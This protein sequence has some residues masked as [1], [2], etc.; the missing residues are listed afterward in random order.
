MDIINELDLTRG[1]FRFPNGRELYIEEIQYSPNGKD[2]W[3]KRFIPHPHTNPNDPT[4]LIDGHKYRRV[5]HAGDDY[6]QFPEYIVAK[7]GDHSVFRMNGKTLQYKLSLEL[8]DE[9]K[10]LFDFSILKGDKGDKG[11]RG[12]GW[13]IDMYGFLDTRPHCDGSIHDEHHECKP[14]NEHRHHNHIHDH[15][16]HHHDH[17]EHH[18][19][20]DHHHDHH[21]DYHH[22]HIETPPDPPLDT[23][24]NPLPNPHVHRHHHI[25]THHGHKHSTFLSLGNHVISHRDVGTT[26]LPKYH[27]INGTTWL[28]T[29]KESIGTIVV[30]WGSGR[31]ETTVNGITTVVFS[32]GYTCNEYGQIIG[33]EQAP[34]IYNSKGI[35]FACA[36]GYWV[37]LSNVATPTGEVK[38]NPV[39][40][41][42]YLDEKL[43]EVTLTTN[44]LKLLIKDLGVT[45]NK[46]AKS[47]FGNGLEYRDDISKVVVDVRPLIGFGLGSYKDRGDGFYNI[48]VKPT[49]FLEDGFDIEQDK[50]PLGTITKGDIWYTAFVDVSDLICPTSGLTA[51]FPLPEE[52]QRPDRYDLFVKPDDGIKV[53]TKGVGLV[54]DNSIFAVTPSGITLL[55]DSIRATHIN[56]D[57]AGIGLYQ[58]N[59]G[60]LNVGARNTVFGFDSKDELYILDN[61]ITGVMINDNI[62]NEKTGLKVISD[63]I[64]LVVNTDYFTFKTSGELTFANDWLDNLLDNKVVKRIYANNISGEYLNNNVVVAGDKSDLYVDIKVDVKDKTLRIIPITNEQAIIDLIKG[65]MKSSDL[66]SIS[67]S[68]A[69]KANIDDA[70][71][72]DVTYGNVM[73][74]KKADKGIRLYDSETDRWYKLNVTTVANEGHITTQLI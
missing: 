15:H 9:W 63:K 20:H 71:M 17:D 51:K 13:H 5:R 33:F 6:F 50:A 35:V 61:A 27:T 64:N 73:I 44:G 29:V 19:H 32:G 12:K 23:N 70:V 11:L 2:T 7:D 43:D 30:G 26:L 40:E 56:S 45:Y 53:T 58:G 14:C 18:E 60:D 46:L 10:D 28:E 68:L 8:D 16:D 21:H 49:D 42:N 22:D 67:K 4:Q 55:P 36:G 57:V 39:D 54:V 69:L 41:L 74:S 34:S 59:S 48:Q 47:V 37:K 65:Y 66:D 52:S 31:T 24:G 62:V 72:L 25:H 1:I 3:E 38:I